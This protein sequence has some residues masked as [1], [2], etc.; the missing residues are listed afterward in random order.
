MEERH[1]TVRAWACLA[2]CLASS[3]GAVHLCAQSEAPIALLLPGA[4]M[5]DFG[6]RELDLQSGQLKHIIWLSQFVGPGSEPS[7]RKKLLVLSFFAAW[8]K[9]CVHE[10]AFLSRLQAAYGPLGLQVLSINLR[11]AGESF[12][13]AVTAARRVM[14]ARLGFPILFDRYTNRNQLLYAGD[15]ATLPSTVLI[16]EDGTLL[17]RLE[18]LNT[19]AL[20]AQVRLTL[21]VP[22]ATA[23]CDPIAP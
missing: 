12:A 23:Y 22:A 10:L 14:P 20:E 19:N 1:G 17:R 3:L 16:G 21:A 9:P 15:K 11:R 7:L 4:A 8:C 18:G 13:M 2:L 6:L 5:E